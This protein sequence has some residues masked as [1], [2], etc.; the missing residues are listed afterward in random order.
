MIFYNYFIRNFSLASFELAFGAFLLLFGVIYGLANWGMDT[1]ALLERFYARKI[2]GL[3]TLFWQHYRAADGEE[4]KRAM[5]DY[6]W[7]AHLD[8]EDYQYAK[9]AVLSRRRRI[10]LDAI[11]KR[12]KRKLDW[13]ARIGELR[14][15][16]SH[17]E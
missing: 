15:R 3:I 9:S 13:I 6:P 7:G 14:M 16:A 4:Q 8:A 2:N 10:Q 17:G 11:L 1:P 5:L 12:N